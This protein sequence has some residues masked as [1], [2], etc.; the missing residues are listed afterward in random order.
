VC[1]FIVTILWLFCL[2]P[3]EVYSAYTAPQRK[4]TIPSAQLTLAFV[5]LWHDALGRGG[6]TFMSVVVIL[7]LIMSTS[8]AVTASSRL[9]FAVARDGILPGSSWIAR[10]TEQGQPRNAV[11]VIL[12][13]A[14]A[15]LLIS[16]GSQ[17]AFTILLSAAATSAS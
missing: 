5:Q 6:A 12:V 10:A 2:P 17:S 3:V 1:T 8:C 7:G 15:L 4:S 16:I 14:T 13:L 9:V 11:T